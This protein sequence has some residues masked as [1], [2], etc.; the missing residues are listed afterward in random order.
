MNETRRAT[1]LRPGAR[2]RATCAVGDEERRVGLVL[3]VVLVLV[4]AMSLYGWDQYEGAM[5]G[6]TSGSPPVAP[7]RQDAQSI[8]I[9]PVSTET[10]KCEC[11]SADGGGI[12]THRSCLKRAGHGT[13]GRASVRAPKY[14][15]RAGV[16]DVERR[17]VLAEDGNGDGV[18]GSSNAGLICV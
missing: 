1:Y 16:H 8:R 7:A 12:R 2:G 17:G 11:P 18:F 5:H 4:R 13:C 10:G 3:A 15:T 9:Y 6:E 14:R